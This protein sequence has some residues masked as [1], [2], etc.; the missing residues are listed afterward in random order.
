MAS[1][2]SALRSARLVAFSGHTT[3]DI[4]LFMM[5]RFEI[6]QFRLARYNTVL[7]AKSSLRANFCGPGQCRGLATVTKVLPVSEFNHN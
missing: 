7:I 2:P 1:E 3:A 6:T 5:T 4:I